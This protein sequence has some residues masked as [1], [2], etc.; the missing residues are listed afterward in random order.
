MSNSEQCSALEKLT[1]NVMDQ[2]AARRSNESGEVSRG[3]IYAALLNLVSSLQVG[4]AFVMGCI[5]ESKSASWLQRAQDVLNLLLKREVGLMLGDEMGEGEV[6]GVVWKL[7]RINPARGDVFHA[8]K[9][10]LRDIENRDIASE[11]DKLA[12]VAAKANANVED[13]KAG[14]EAV[15]H[16]KALPDFLSRRSR[17]PISVVGL[18]GDIPPVFDN[19]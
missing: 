10:R 7:R 17:E 18:V 4:R 2:P 9:R 14:L 16:A 5:L 8:F 6:E 19:G 3:S 1:F 15:A 11:G 13:T 12:G